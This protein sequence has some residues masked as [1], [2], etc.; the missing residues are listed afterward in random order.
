MVLNDKI[1]FLTNLFTYGNMG[2]K[3]T[4]LVCRASLQPTW[5]SWRPPSAERCIGDL[6][7]TQTWSPPTTLTHTHTHIWTISVELSTVT[8]RAFSA[9]AVPRVW[10]S[11][12]DDVVSVNCQ[13]HS[14]LRP[15]SWKV[16]QKDSQPEWAC[17][18]FQ[19]NGLDAW[20]QLL[21]SQL[22]GRYMQQHQ[23]LRLDTIMW[24]TCHPCD[25][26]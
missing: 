24:L 7:S 6:Q 20:R 16:S 9:T 19:T 15:G 8:D 10:N 22:T 5:Q 23:R 17:G 1:T 13:W 18:W 4:F 12:V 3:N 11:L 14:L 26:T 21:T 2:R 25:A